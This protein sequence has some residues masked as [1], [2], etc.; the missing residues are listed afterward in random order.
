[1]P[2]NLG[3]H[4]K[5]ILN[6]WYILFILQ[7]PGQH[8][9]SGC[10][11][12]VLMNN[13]LENGP[14]AVRKGAFFCNKKGM[15]VFFYFEA[16]RSL[17]KYPSHQDLGVAPVL[18]RIRLWVLQFLLNIFSVHCALWC[19]YL[20]NTIGTFNS[21]SVGRMLSNWLRSLAKQDKVQME[22]IVH[23]LGDILFLFSL[24]LICNVLW[25]NF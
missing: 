16:E 8:G 10:I 13:G 2:F 18:C 12:P 1:M 4:E 20:L 6:L 9:C 23:S 22:W 24:F 19:T 25:R 11:A 7:G 21:K 17:K 5:Y 14:L 3:I 15:Y